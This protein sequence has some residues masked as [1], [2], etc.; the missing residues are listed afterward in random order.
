M[1]E[2]FNDSITVTRRKLIVD[3]PK[4]IR[5]ALLNI[6]VKNNLKSWKI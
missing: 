3:M 4:D 5:H 6:M 2:V 1:S